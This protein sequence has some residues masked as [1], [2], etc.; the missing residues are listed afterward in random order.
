MSTSITLTEAETAL[1]ES[2]GPEAA[3]FRTSVRRQAWNKSRRVFESTED[4]RYPPTVGIYSSD[5]I[6]LDYQ[7]WDTQQ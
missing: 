7:E 3:W 1:W 2:D 6:T 4:M 5:G